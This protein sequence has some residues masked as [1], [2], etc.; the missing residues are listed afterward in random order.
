M[1]RRWLIRVY[2]HYR[3]MGPSPFIAEEFLSFELVKTRRRYRCLKHRGN[4]IKWAALS[5]LMLD[6]LPR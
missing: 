5:G 1:N 4:S 2:L 6:I 3:T